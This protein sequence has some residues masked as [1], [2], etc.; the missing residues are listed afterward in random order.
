MQARNKKATRNIVA[1]SSRAPAQ[2]ARSHSTSLSESSQ[3]GEKRVRVMFHDAKP[4]RDRSARQ[5]ARGLAQYLARGS[6]DS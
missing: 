5:A 4:N 2:P 3:G 6:P 1:W